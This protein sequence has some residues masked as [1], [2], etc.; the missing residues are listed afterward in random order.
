MIE[1]YIHYGQDILSK[2]A[3]N[4][5][6]TEFGLAGLFANSVLAST[7][8]PLPVEI[9]VSALL[10]AGENAF[11]V[12]MTLASGTV[13]GGF[14][15]YFIGRSGDKVFHFLKP[16]TEEKHH[17]KS[18]DI[19]AKY[20]WIAFVMAPWL[21]DFGDIIIMIA[22]AKSYD[23][24]KFAIAMTIGKIVRA[25]ATV[26]FIGLVATRLFGGT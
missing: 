10:A 17:K 12:L 18:H 14:L 19:L 2:L 4:P 26:Y 11:L 7:A 24:R 1:Q 20:G 8:L 9:T 16:K 15:S 13:V 5:V 3:A 22:G 25:T 23:F 6:F 21:P